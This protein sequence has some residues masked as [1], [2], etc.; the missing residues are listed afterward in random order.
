MAAT[1]SY[2]T[3][4]EY[5]ER[6]DQSSS[7]LD[8]VVAAHLAACSRLLDKQCNRFFSRDAAAVERVFDG[9]TSIIQRLDDHYVI[10]NPNARTRLYLPSDI[11]TT[12]GLIVKVDLDGDYVA[13]TTLTLNT[14]YWVGEPNA[15]L[16]SEPWPYT[17]LEVIPTS[18][19]LFTWPA[20]R[21]G[22]A[23]TAVWGW[24]AVPAALKEATVMLASE[25]ID[26]QRGGAVLT[27]N[28]LDAAVGLSPRAPKILGDTVEV[29]GRKVP[30]FA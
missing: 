23:V 25:F 6:V 5:K 10:W 16:G 26:L 20:Q 15:P 28:N 11:A 8:G 7:V 1:D 24:P 9:G 14:D 29:Y 17:W 21:R 4:A 2:A 19:K 13:E 22:L 27:L 18:G 3:V 30:W 12:T